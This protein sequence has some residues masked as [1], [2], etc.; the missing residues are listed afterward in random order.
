M[1]TEAVA[2]EIVEDLLRSAW[3][4]DRARSVV[5]DE[6]AA[7]ADRFTAAAARARRRAEILE[8]ELEQ[9]ERRPDHELVDG[10]AAWIRSLL[11][12]G[13]SQTPLADLFLVRLGDWVEAHASPFMSVAVDEFKQIAEQERAAMSFPDDLPP[14]PPF[15]PLAPVEVEAPGEV[16]FRFG[17]LGDLHIGS[18]RAEAA[19]RA[20]VDDLNALGVDL[21]IQLG[22]ITD[23]GNKDQFEK[24]AEILA[25][26]EMPYA[27]MLGNHD[28]F[29]RGEGRLS[30][31]EYYTPL[32]GREPD[33]VLLEHKGFRFAVLDS[34]DLGAS[35]FAPFDLVAGK[36]TEGPGG[37]VVGGALTEPQHEILASIAAPGGAPTFVFL[38]HPPQPFTSFP[39]L[40]FG[41]R[42]VD[43]GRLHAT[44]DSGNVWGVFA[45]HTHRNARSRTFGRV[46]AHELAIPRDFPFGIG[47]VD[48]ADQGYAFRFLQL[49][50]EALVEQ[51]SPSALL[52]HRRYGLGDEVARGFSWTAGGP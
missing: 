32:F 2:T 52:I 41:L 5:F 10:H 15:E 1:S 16:R 29:S 6:W 13:P 24:A 37:A 9:R 31:N 47:V 21:V 51:M 25:G 34:A 14:P 3:V 39:P 36:F 46:P 19:A 49:S 43:T 35:P 40:L 23:Q 11:G 28:V 44:C 12:R 42:D 45:G 17:I 50:D 22:D 48:V 8:T 33:G 30:G 20:A 7:E 26:L 18:A 27:T 4:V 38:H